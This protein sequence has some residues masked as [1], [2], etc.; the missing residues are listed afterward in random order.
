MISSYP[1]PSN[2]PLYRV[3]GTLTGGIVIPK[4]SA[5][6]GYKEL[7]L[8]KYAA[9]SFSF[10]SIYLGSSKPYPEPDPNSDLFIKTLTGKTIG[11][12]CEMNETIEQIKEMIQDREGIPPDQQ[13]LIFAGKQLEDGKTLSDHKITRSSTLHLVLRL[14]GGGPSILTVPHDLFDRAYDYDFTNINDSGKFFKRGGLPYYR[15][16]GCKRYALKVIDKYDG[17]ENTWLGSSNSP[18]EWAN[19]Y[20]G[21]SNK[22]AEPIVKWGLKVG[23][24]N[25]YGLGIYCT[26]NVRT[27][28]EYSEI[29]TEFDTEKQYKIVFQ[30]RVRVEAI[31]R[32][33]DKGG[34]NDYWYVS[35]TADI[36]PYAICVYEK[37]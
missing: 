29:Y 1:K 10:G 37:W 7:S 13:R 32:A 3:L 33:S 2:D 28:L 6:K 18:G 24:R 20:H 26:P 5:D 35:D 17:G 25:A 36:R 22:N 21:T 11:L 8:D 19:S 23:V 14:R 16:C 30:N 15:P 9:F 12:Y 34:P 4:K 27:A 31:H